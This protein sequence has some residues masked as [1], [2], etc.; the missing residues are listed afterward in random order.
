MRK[1]IE[2]EVARLEAERNLSRVC[3]VVDMDMFF[4]AVE[5]RDDP[6][7]IGKPV[8]VGGKSMI[9]TANYE[10]RKF[11]VRSAMPGFIALE[12]C[13]RW[14]LLIEVDVTFEDLAGHTAFKDSAMFH[15]LL[16]L[17]ARKIRCIH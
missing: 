10:A 11:G 16:L 4:A 13:I 8:A 12:L 9:S 2:K 15:Q 17:R 6:S 14:W 3:V 1:K 5:M 7:L